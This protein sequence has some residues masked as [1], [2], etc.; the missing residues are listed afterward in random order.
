MQ[1]QLSTDPNVTASIHEI[2][3]KADSQL[4]MSVIKMI[5]LVP[6]VI[7]RFMQSFVGLQCHYAFVLHV[8][9]RLP[10]CQFNCS[11]NPRL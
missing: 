5:V 6:K 7:D 4:I 3:C 9:S 1:N 2:K 10:Q 8:L 11:S